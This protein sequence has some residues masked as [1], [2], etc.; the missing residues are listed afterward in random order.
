MALELTGSDQIM[1]GWIKAHMDHNSDFMVTI[2]IS[3]QTVLSPADVI[4]SIKHLVELNM[5]KAF[6]QSPRYK[7]LP[8][9]R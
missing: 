5:I 2:D 3:V 1:L 8:E 7:L 6:G 9:F 4:Y